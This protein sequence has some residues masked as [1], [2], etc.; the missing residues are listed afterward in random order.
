MLALGI[1]TIGHKGTDRPKEMEAQV[2]FADINT[3]TTIFKYR[4]GVEKKITLHEC[5]WLT[6]LNTETVDAN[7]ETH[8]STD[9]CTYAFTPT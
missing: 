6:K 1:K 2:R 8:R 5:S 4:Q 7:T 9:M 3:D